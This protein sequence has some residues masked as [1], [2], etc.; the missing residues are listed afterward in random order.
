MSPEQAHG[1]PVDR[2]SDVWSFGCLLFECLAG[3]AAFTGETVSDLIRGGVGM[4]SAG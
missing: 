1:K 2:R 3:R 4:K